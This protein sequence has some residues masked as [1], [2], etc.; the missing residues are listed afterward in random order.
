MPPTSE[1]RSVFFSLCRESLYGQQL[2]PCSGRAE[3]LCRSRQPLKPHTQTTVYVLEETPAGYRV[4]YSE[5]FKVGYPRS[6]ESDFVR[7]DDPLRRL[8]YT[9]F[10]AIDDL[11]VSGPRINARF[12]VQVPLAGLNSYETRSADVLIVEET[13]SHYRLRFN[14]A[15]AKAYPALC[16]EWVRKDSKQQSVQ[17]IR[18]ADF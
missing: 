18:C 16:R 8:T 7:R 6:C 5:S 10:A 17:L 11:Q 2:Q 3:H 15:F 13:R 9:R 4:Y 14:P 1:R 12:F